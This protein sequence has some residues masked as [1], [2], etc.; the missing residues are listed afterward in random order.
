MA[1]IQNII[2]CNLLNCFLFVGCCRTL[3]LASTGLTNTSHP[4]VSGVY[5]HAWYSNERTYYQNGRGGYLY[6]VYNDE[7]HVGSRINLDESKTSRSDYY[8]YLDSNCYDECPSTCK[9]WKTY[10]LDNDG[11]SSNCPWIVDATFTIKC[12]GWYLII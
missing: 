4:R 3:V 5:R 2:P 1:L 8:S 10:D 11:C 12:S 6:W 9:I 7:W